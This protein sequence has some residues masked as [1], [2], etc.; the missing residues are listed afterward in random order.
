MFYSFEGI[1]P[2]HL[3]IPDLNI[4]LNFSAGPDVFWNMTFGPSNS[5]NAYYI[6][7]GT[8]E[9][10]EHCKQCLQCQAV[11]YHRDMRDM[12]N[13]FVLLTFTNT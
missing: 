3:K 4:H 6:V 1:L 7:N 8:T 11:S 5:E 13:K 9:Y 2:R 10:G 12:F